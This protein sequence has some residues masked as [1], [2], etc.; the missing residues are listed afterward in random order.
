MHRYPK[1]KQKL[2]MPGFYPKED[3][4]NRYQITGR[5]SPSA[6]CIAK[7][8]HIN[9]HLDEEYLPKDKYSRAGL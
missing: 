1:E 7:Q 6:S 9:I 3:P 4:H 8:N 2:I 5:L